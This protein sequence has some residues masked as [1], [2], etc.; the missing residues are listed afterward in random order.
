M[1]INFVGLNTCKHFF[2]SNAAGLTRRNV[3]TLINN[4]WNFG[5]KCSLSEESEQ[6]SSE[7]CNC[8]IWSTVLIQYN[9]KPE[10]SLY[11]IK[12]ADIR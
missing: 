2:F 1:H 10:V 3:L 5:F 9:I 12:E 8:V 7:E 4:D 11:Q 6:I